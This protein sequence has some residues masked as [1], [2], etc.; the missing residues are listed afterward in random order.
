VVYGKDSHYRNALREMATR[1]AAHAGELEKKPN[2]LMALS[3]VPPAKSR[4]GIP[5]PQSLPVVV[6]RCAHEGHL[7]PYGGDDEDE[8]V[9]GLDHP[10]DA[11]SWQAAID[12]DASSDDQPAVLQIWTHTEASGNERGAMEEG[13]PFKDEPYV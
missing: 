10:T 4:S 8:G 5:I 11:V 2:P 7:V 9:G 6:G 1:N 12:P 13:E 3:P